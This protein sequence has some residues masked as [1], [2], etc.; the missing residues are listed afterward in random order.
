[1]NTTYAPHEQR[2]IDEQAELVSRISKLNTFIT[3]GQLYGQLPLE[4][5]MLLSEQLH[6][7]QGYGHVLAK[8]IARFMPSVDDFELPTKACDLS[9][10]GTCEACQ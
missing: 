5:R 1:M 2:V 3:S 8:R 6:W 10:E 4:D 9:G 7:M